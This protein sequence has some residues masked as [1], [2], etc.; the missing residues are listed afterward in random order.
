M[1]PYFSQNYI[2]LVVLVVWTLL[3]KGYALWTSAKHNQKKWF[4]VLLV[5]N[6]VG[7]LEI[8]YI[9]YIMKKSRADVKKDFRKALS[10]FK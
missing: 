2:V 6:T 4:V 7:I 10:S 1:Y 8:F 3:W 9:F 5:L